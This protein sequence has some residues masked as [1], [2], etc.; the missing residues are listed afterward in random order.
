MVTA[1]S[2]GRLGLVLRSTV[3]GRS[4]GKKR[5][6]VARRRRWQNVGEGRRFEARLEER[7]WRKKKR[8]EDVQR[9]GLI[10]EKRWGGS[11][12]MLDCFGGCRTV[13]AVGTASARLPGQ[14]LRQCNNRKL[15][16]F[17]IEGERL[18]LFVQQE[19]LG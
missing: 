5:G 13:A 14:L 6:K 7:W 4:C 1:E 18:P 17:P 15:S 9:G 12:K 11:L 2:I 19:R 16:I 3:N 8:F 10:G